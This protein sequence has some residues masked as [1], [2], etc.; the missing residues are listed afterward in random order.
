MEIQMDMF[1]DGSDQAVLKT[2]CVKNK[3]CQ[4]A[5]LQSVI[6][7]AYRTQLISYPYVQSV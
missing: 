5:S 2:V 1:P 6:E 4:Q 7:M 3:Y